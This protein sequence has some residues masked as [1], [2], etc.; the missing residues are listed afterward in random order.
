MQADIITKYRNGFC[1]VRDFLCKCRDSG[2]SAREYQRRFSLCYVRK[3]NFQFRAFRDDLDAY[4]GLV[5]VNKPGF[6]YRVSHEHHIPDECTIFSFDADFYEELAARYSA[7]FGGF[8]KDRDRPSM[9]IRPEMAA[10]YLHH[11]ILTRLR[12][13]AP[14]LEVDSLILELVESVLGCPQKWS[15]LQPL[16]SSQKKHHLV[17]VEEAKQFLQ[18][19]FS[20]DISL[21]DVATA[22]HTSKFHFSRVFRRIAGITPHQYLMRFRLNHAKQLLKNGSTSVTQAAFDSGFS[23]SNYFSAAFKN[24]YN[25]SPS[26]YLK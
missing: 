8:F 17:T 11:R 24:H 4:N 10:E 21:D 19:H 15:D 18:T 13:G 20:A 3:G 16:T 5:L 9:L 6:E 22:C 25:T 26:T 1:E 12:V 2:L 23:D 14:S 7:H